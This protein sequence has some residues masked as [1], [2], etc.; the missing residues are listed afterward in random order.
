MSEIPILV[1][2]ECVNNDNFD[3]FQTEIHF[4]ELNFILF[5]CYF[6]FISH[7][8]KL[9][10]MTVLCVQLSMSRQNCGSSR[11]SACKH[12][13]LF[14]NSYWFCFFVCIFRFQKNIVCYTNF[15]IDFSI[16]TLFEC[17]CLTLKIKKKNQHKKLEFK[18]SVLFLWN[19]VFCVNLL[20]LS[21]SNSIDCIAIK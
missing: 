13:S 8:Q 5:F 2:D 3:A 1:T 7:I 19:S 16:V 14:T 15:S 10:F 18:N 12:R 20:F 17:D 4:N 6:L 21:Q 9:V 11:R